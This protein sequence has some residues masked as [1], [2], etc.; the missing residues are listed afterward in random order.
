MPRS[1]FKLVVKIQDKVERTKRLMTLAR[2]SRGSYA[3][4][5]VTDAS[6]TYPGTTVT[7]G[8]VA[9]WNE[10]GEGRVPSRSFLRTPVDDM[11]PL[12][13]R[14]REQL[15]ENMIAGEVS[16]AAA[17]EALGFLVSN[18]IKNAII[19]GIGPPLKPKTIE[20]KRE[21]RASKGPSP[22]PETPLMDT[23]LLISKI[24]Y[25]VYLAGGGE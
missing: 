23:G 13:N 15:L 19:R 8:Q 4:V 20:R 14:K 17:L 1:G 7:V 9:A 2:A 18:G 6:E 21:Q 16:V 24:G 22:T 25:E 5:G 3:V 12:I 11:Q 10:F